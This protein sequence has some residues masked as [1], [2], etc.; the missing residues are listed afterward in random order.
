MKKIK[1]GGLVKNKIGFSRWILNY[2]EYS[3]ELS[4]Y[5]EDYDKT[6]L[7]FENRKEDLEKELESLRKIS[8]AEIDKLN[9]IIVE[10][11]NIIIRDTDSLNARNKEIQELHKELSD[12]LLEIDNLKANIKQLNCQKGGLIKEINKLK[13]ANEFLKANRRAPNKEEILAYEKNI[14]GLLKREKVAKS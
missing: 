2:K 6:K 9:E 13:K 1:S 10:K 5:R 7:E 8:K 14:K 3:K 4:D 11:T 12:K